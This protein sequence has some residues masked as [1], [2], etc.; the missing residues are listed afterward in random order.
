MHQILLWDTSLYGFIWFFLIYSVLGWCAEVAA[1]AVTLGKFIN[2][3][4]LNGS[5]CPIYGFGMVL[6][7]IC[8]TPIK[9]NILLLFLGS[10]VLT[11]LLELFTGFVLEKVFHTKWW[12]YS[13]EKLNIKGY[14]CVRYSLLWGIACVGVMK[15]I[16]PFIV[17]LID[18]I[19]QLLGQILIIILIS[20]MLA[21]FIT[22]IISL[23]GM[24]DRMKKAND[25][26]E[27]I[28]SN[29]DRVGE[30]ITNETLELQRK[31][32]EI[33][34]KKNRIQK[35]L[36]NAYPALADLDKKIN[37]EKLKE[38]IKEKIEKNGKK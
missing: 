36:E 16:H 29:S 38:Q 4:F 31:L 27:K 22:V 3:G 7:V 24:S 12:D 14:I 19:P 28:Q 23:T 18:L 21:D 20:G 13:K 30:R 5:Y 17:K 35:R 2:R 1:H 6:V 34:D 37:K 10:V 32:E 9:D 8:L 26:R 15:I 25:I 33:P 11:T